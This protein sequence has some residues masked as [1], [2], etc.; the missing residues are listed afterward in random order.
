MVPPVS[1]DPGYADLGV[2]PDTAGNTYW[3]PMTS[4]SA[5]GLK[6]SNGTTA[7]TGISLSASNTIDPSPMYLTNYGIALYDSFW[8]SAMDDGNGGGVATI[9]VSGLNPAKSY[10]LYVYAWFGSPWGFGPSTFTIDA[11]TS[12]DSWTND[13]VGGDEFI[14]DGN[15]HLFAGLTPTAGGT[16]GINFSREEDV[17]II[18]AFQLVSQGADVPE[19]STLALLAAGLA[20]MLAY[21]WRKRK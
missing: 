1:D 17:G 10:D 16:I 11:A 6:Y 15:Y 20:G 21:A 9:T 19:P 8:Q 5:T 7:A 13:D 18:S 12:P 2:A 4:T 3:N 14:A